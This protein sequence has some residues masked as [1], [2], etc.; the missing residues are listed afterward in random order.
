MPAR[1]AS[2][3]FYG[4]GKAFE[5]LRDSVWVNEGESDVVKNNLLN[6][7]KDIRA[8]MPNTNLAKRGNM[9]VVDVD[10]PGIKDN[11]VAH[12]KI[13]AELDKGVD[14]ADFSYL[15]PE[16]ERTFT[17]YV[18]DQYPR[19]HDTEAKILEDRASQITD[20]NVSGTI[21]LYSCIFSFNLHRK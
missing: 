21:N 11:F 5:G 7:V 10:V 3:S 17:A 1:L 4:A 15:K 12:S 6:N 8:Q 16:N 9:A 19:Y 14:V 13:N 20:P 2:L 18:D